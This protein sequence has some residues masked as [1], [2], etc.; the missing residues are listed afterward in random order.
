MLLK[1]T[2]QNVHTIDFMNNFGV[3]NK[4]TS[5]HIFMMMVYCELV[6]T[7]DTFPLNHR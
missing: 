1:I 7:L 3:G 2:A 6:Q 4:I 5:N